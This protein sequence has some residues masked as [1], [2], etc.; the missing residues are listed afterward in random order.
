M[1]Q[2]LRYGD[3]AAWTEGDATAWAA[4]LRSPAGQKLD[5]MMT[6]LVLDTMQEAVTRKGTEYDVGTS[7][8]VR[9]TWVQLKTLS[10]IG[11]APEDDSKE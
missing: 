1:R 11:V 7:N 9:Q 10:A 2:A 8:G 3:L 6:H 4:F 5:T